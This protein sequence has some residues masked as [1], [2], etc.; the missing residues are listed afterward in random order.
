MNRRH[1][2][3]TL[4]LTL[5]ALPAVAA[6]GRRPRIVLRNA[7]QSINIGD[8]AHYLGFFELMEK[9][10]ID[11]EF[12]LWPGTLKDGADALLA[13]RFPK[14]IVLDTP[15]KITA[16]IQE[17]DFLVSG[18][19][20]GFGGSSAV[21]RW[22]KE[23]PGKPYGVFG[24][25]FLG[26]S[27]ED[28]D[29]LNHA[30]FVFFR[31]SVGLAAARENGVNCPIMEYGPDSAFGVVTLRNDKAALAFMHANG[32][33]EGK[34]LCCIPRYRMTPHWIIQKAR[35]VDPVKAKRN[36]EMK[37]H[38]HAPLRE[39]IIA[40]T[41]QTDLK[42]LICH[43]DQTQISLGKEMIYDKLPEE[44]KKKCVWKDS[45]W[46]TDEALSTYVRSAGLFGNEMHSPIMCIA[47]GIP[48]VV[49]RF[50][51]QT[52][53]GYMWRDI[54]LNDWL[55][56]LDIEEEVARIVPT[57]LDIAKNPAKAKA[58]AAQGREKMLQF[59]QREIDV[60]K[61][62]VAQAIK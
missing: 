60:L 3:S 20:S 6:E 29:N 56:D 11:A 22:R 62:A 25:S 47:S 42:V 38:D 44:T 58:Y 16:A 61:G 18:S 35:P 26:G 15:E 30:Q 51:D 17:C 27:P 53:K 49:C 10:K 39:A 12:R 57:V 33:E 54:G 32:L 24:I 28:V 45:Y 19:S 43:E 36:D 55:F 23:A 40:V 1:F 34:F 9:H 46:L 2:L 37:E 7:W 14:V 52:I 8:I 48:A 59:Q 4:A 50:K 5:A 31:D 21:S 41:S 13:R